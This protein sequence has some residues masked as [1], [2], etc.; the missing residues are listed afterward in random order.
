MEAQD[1]YRSILD[2]IE[3]VLGWQ[4]EN[5]R[6]CSRCGI[7]F[8]RPLNRSKFDRRILLCD[9]CVLVDTVLFTPEIKGDKKQAEHNFWDAS[10]WVAFK[11][12]LI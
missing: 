4:E 11:D 5:P 8:D 3:T 2:N 7:E 10:E 9:E 6:R 12:R 1:Q